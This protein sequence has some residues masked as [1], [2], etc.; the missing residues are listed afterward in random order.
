MRPGFPRVRQES[1]KSRTATRC[2]NDEKSSPSL[3]RDLLTPFSP[4]RT[5]SYIANS[6]SLFAWALRYKGAVARLAP[7]LTELLALHKGR[8]CVTVFVLYFIYGLYRWLQKF[9]VYITYYCILKKKRKKYILKGERN[10][11]YPVQH[12]TKK[13]SQNIAAMVKRALQKY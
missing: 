11:M 1:S 10:T 2:M 3:C 5:K 4:R 7:R 13:A 8:A 9:I 6:E 12:C